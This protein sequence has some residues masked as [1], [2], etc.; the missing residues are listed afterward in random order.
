M[1]NANS[2][3]SPEF[4]LDKNRINGDVHNPKTN[5]SRCGYFSESIPYNKNSFYLLS[6]S[7]LNTCCSL[8]V[9]IGTVKGMRGKRSKKTEG[10]SDRVALCVRLMLPL[11]VKMRNYNTI[12]TSSTGIV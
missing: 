3:Y 10:N 2:F 9:L 7:F 1:L 4:S 11:L 6:F 8:S 5:S 12:Q